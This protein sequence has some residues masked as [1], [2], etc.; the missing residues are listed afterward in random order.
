M[1][2]HHGGIASAKKAWHHGGNA[3]ASASA[4][5]ETPGSAYQHR[6]SLSALWRAASSALPA[7]RWQQLAGISGSGSNN[8]RT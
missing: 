1:A 2:W 8:Q 3:R 5:I 4:S 7:K 6:A